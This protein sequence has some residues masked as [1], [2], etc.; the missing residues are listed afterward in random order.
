MSRWQVRDH[1]IPA[2]GVKAGRVQQHDARIA[3]VS[4]FEV[5]DSC[6]TCLKVVLGGLVVHAFVLPQKPGMVDSRL[7]GVQ[8]HR[9]TEVV[10]QSYFRIGVVAPMRIEFA[11]ITPMRSDRLLVRRSGVG[12]AKAAAAAKTLIGDGCE[13]IISWGFCGA[14]TNLTPGDIV[15]AGCVIDESTDERFTSP[16][17]LPDTVI[18]TEE[19]A[20]R[21]RKSELASGGALAVDMESAAIARTCDAENVAF[22]VFRVVVDDQRANW[23][24]KFD[25]S[26]RMS[27]PG[28]LA[29]AM[30]HPLEL[31]VAG[32]SIYR[33]KV[34]LQRLSVELVALLG[35]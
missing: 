15:R 31:I 34:A 32:Y 12:P 13:L 24:S 29:V 25:G 28:K 6:T 1:L 23:P 8:R 11:Q 3:R 20:G 35:E 17:P 30:K 27:L 2:P 19:V 14:L 26:A 10:T 33:A 22:A 16:L 21:T 5:A 4:P 9:H 7:R 18:S